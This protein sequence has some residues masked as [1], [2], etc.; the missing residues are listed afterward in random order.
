MA[1][2][3]LELESA[4]VNVWEIGSQNQ[5]MYAA[6]VANSSSNWKSAGVTRSSQTSRPSI[7]TNGIPALFPT[8]LKTSPPASPGKTSVELPLSSPVHVKVAQNRRQAR[9]RE[10]KRKVYSQDENHDYEGDEF[11]ALGGTVVLD[12]LDDVEKH[13]DVLGAKVWVAC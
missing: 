9:T 7:N 12:L 5:R 10:G 6:S 13:V 8:P 3:K 2:F 1:A 11:M 4:R